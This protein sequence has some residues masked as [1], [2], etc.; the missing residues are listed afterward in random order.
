MND[1]FDDDVMART[2]P[3]CRTHFKEYVVPSDAGC[4]VCLNATLRN[5]LHIAIR[6]WMR[7]HGAIV[8]FSAQERA[9]YDKCTATLAQNGDGT[10]H[11]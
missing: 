10:C 4:V 11:S 3:L 5:A 6:Y 9:D 8:S 1:G 7:R 2:I